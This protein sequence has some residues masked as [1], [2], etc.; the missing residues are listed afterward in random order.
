M[1]SAVLQ[2]REH[3]TDTGGCRT[4]AR[5]KGKKRT[6]LDLSGRSRD[7]DEHALKAADGSD[8]ASMLTLVMA[9]AARKGIE[10]QRD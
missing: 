2:S 10:E 3:R 1:R 6:C 4:A 9:L 5:R 7:L 8:A